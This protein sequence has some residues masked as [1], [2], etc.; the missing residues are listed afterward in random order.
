MITF[1]CSEEVEMA[2]VSTTRHIKV[3]IGCFEE[4]NFLQIFRFF[5]YKISFQDTESLLCLSTITGS[6]VRSCV[7]TDK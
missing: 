7:S 6:S 5:I 1:K 4:G 3:S 2:H